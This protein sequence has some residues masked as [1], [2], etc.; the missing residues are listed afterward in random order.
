MRELFVTVGASATLLSNLLRL[1]VHAMLTS[2]LPGPPQGSET[3]KEEGTQEWQAG[4]MVCSYWDGHRHPLGSS[5]MEGQS[6]FF[7][8]R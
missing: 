7:Q 2:S 5:L 1:T 8:W 6:V 3:L 4:R